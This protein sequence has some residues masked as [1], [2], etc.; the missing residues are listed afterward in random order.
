M[1]ALP[2]TTRS[3]AAA[4]ALARLALTACGGSSNA[5]SS[6]SS[7]SSAGAGAASSAAGGA[8]KN[9][10]VGGANFT[11]M[12]VA[13]QLYGQVLAKNGYT[14]TYKAVDNREVYE[15]ALEQ[16]QISMVPSTPR[17]WRTS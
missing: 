7:S 11:E 10:T 9:L 3:L 17:P 2:S 6:S 4:V 5:F 8:G 13:Q 12:L 16:G 15:P 14:V 1:K